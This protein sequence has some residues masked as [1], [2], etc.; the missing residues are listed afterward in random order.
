MKQPAMKFNRV[1]LSFPPAVE[2]LFRDKYFADSLVAFRLAFFLVTF[3]YALFGILDSKI[4]PEFASTFHIIR[5]AIVVPVLSITLVI[6]FL[7]IFRKIWQELLVFCFIVGGAGISVMTVLAP[8][9]IFY[10]AGFMLIFMA[11]YFFIKLRFLSATIGGWTVLLIFNLGAVLSGNTPGI[12]LLANNF[13]FVSA[14]IIGMFAAYSIEFYARRD[15]YLNHELDQQKREVE[16]ANR[17]LESKIESRTHQLRE[18]K[19]RAEESDRLKSAFIS[20]I[21]HEIRTPLN[22]IIGF[23]EIIAGQE[24]SE[25]EKLDYL[26]VL[27]SSSNRLLQTITDYMDIAHIVSG[28]QEVIKSRFSINGLLEELAGKYRQACMDKNLLLRFEIP[29]GNR[30]WQLVS[31]RDLVMKTFQQLIDNAV[32]FTDQGEIIIGFRFEGIVTHFFVRDSGRGI[33]SDKLDMI[34]KIFTQEE[35]A[36]TR[37]YEGSGLGLAIAKGIVEMLGGKMIAKSEKNKGSEFSFTLSGD[38]TVIDL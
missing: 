2:K 1:T 14:N 23:G 33:S 27:R 13:F 21:S 16:E 37:G 9:N 32:K 38:I 36:P 7:P 34:F 30:E 35:T 29:E 6:S 26:S 3:L 12:L 4:V 10:Y 18:A 31:D 15:F 22:G 20:N 11:G 19:E 28:T 5:Y 24:L 17:S 25:K 8:V